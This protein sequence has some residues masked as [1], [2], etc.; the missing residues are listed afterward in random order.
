MTKI[1]T[2]QDVVPNNHSISF[3]IKRMEDIYDSVKGK[4][5]D[6]HRHDYYI[7]LIVLKAKGK[8]IIDFHEFDLKGGQMYFVSPGQVHQII[9]EEKSYG[10]A[11]TF[12]QQFLVFNY[13]ESSFVDNLYLFQENGYSP[14]LDLSP[15]ELKRA[16]FFGE[17]ILKVNG[18]ECKMKYE[19]LGAWLKLLL[20]LAQDACHLFPTEH[21]QNIQAGKVLL[22]DFKTL[23]DRHYQE[24]HKV[25]DYAV[26]LNITSD[27]LNTSVNNLTG[28]NVKL[29]IQNRIL[30]AAKRM[31]LFSEFSHKEIA[32]ELGFSEPANF[33]QFFKKQ[34]QQSP[35]AFK[36]SF[37]NSAEF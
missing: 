36:K 11:I 12:S 33:S 32:Y 37:K 14:P 21:T 27:Y 3:E 24:W 18:A 13:I 23:L 7:I 17:E 9:E 6:P 25:S 26:A 30:L 1:K 22:H 28:K 35:T 8:H 15:E 16:L 29:H 20:I 2:Y 5:D 19:T 10:Y 34:T 4:V 31:L